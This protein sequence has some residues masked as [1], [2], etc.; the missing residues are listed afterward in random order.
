[1]RKLTG[2]WYLK[3]SWLF[4][5]KVMVEVEMTRKLPHSYI[6]LDT[7]K[8]YEEADMSDLMVLGIKVIIWKH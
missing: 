2:K 5:Y 7:Y 8:I 1:M 6:F 4:G 3:K